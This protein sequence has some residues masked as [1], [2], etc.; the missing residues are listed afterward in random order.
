MLLVKD[1]ICQSSSAVKISV[2][3]FTP[4]E[5]GEEVIMGQI[6]GEEKK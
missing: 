4:W 3:C 6:R 2:V 1:M 5:R